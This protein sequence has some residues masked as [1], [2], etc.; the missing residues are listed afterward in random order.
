[1]SRF[2][3]ILLYSMV[4][5]NLMLIGILLLRQDQPNSSLTRSAW[6]A[7]TGFG[8]T[9]RYSPAVD[10][11]RKASPA[12]VSVTAIQYVNRPMQQY[13]DEFFGPFVPFG[14]QVQEVPMLGSGFIIDPAGYVITNHH[15]VEDASSVSVTLPDGREF[16]AKVLDADVYVDIALLKIEGKNL[17]VAPLGTSTDLMIGEGV[18]AIGNP[19]GQF[20][21]DPRPTVTLG[22][23]SATGRYFRPQSSGDSTRVYMDMI[24]TDAAI[25]P[26]NSGGPLVNLDGNVV[27]MN[28][29]I[30]SRTGGSQGLGFAIPVEKIK[31]IV[32]EVQK[33]GHLR[34]L[35]LDVETQSMSRALARHFNLPADTKGAIVTRIQDK[36]PAQRAGLQLGDIIVRVD[37][38]K[39]N[40]AEDLYAYFV[41]LQVGRQIEM[42]VIR[43]GKHQV[44]KYTVEEGKQ[45]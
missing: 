42:E 17:P 32:A 34:S 12:V 33:Y 36:G 18:M 1:M 4:P 35:L 27:G 25:N 21:D 22:V 5:L 44:L 20:Y 8:Q 10:A 31:S 7:P 37:A 6:S 39:V 14:N 30:I 26:G 3:R 24:Q 45:S 41:T 23:V 38:R 15:V 16:K 29:F 2:Q 9:G 11:A 40:D 28:T 43:D 13:Y 19:F